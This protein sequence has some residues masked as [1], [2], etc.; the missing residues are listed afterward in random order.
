MWKL[1]EKEFYDV[2]DVINAGFN[3]EPMKCRNCGSLEVTFSQYIGD[4]QCA[5]CGEWQLELPNKGKD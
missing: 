3:L 5:M 1:E 2:Q 4:A